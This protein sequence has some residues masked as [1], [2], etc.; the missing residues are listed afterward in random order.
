MKKIK[1]FAVVL[2]AA[3][4]ACLMLVGFSGCTQKGDRE[5]PE[6]VCSWEEISFTPAKCETDASAT[7]KCNGCGKIDTVALPGTATGHTLKTVEKVEATCLKEGREKS[8]KCENCSYEIS[9]KVIPKL[10]HD[11]NYDETS[12]TYKGSKPANCQQGSYCGVCKTY[13]GNPVNNHTANIVRVAER[14]PTCEEDGWKTYV[15]CLGNPEEGI[16]CSYST[17]DNAVVP[18]QGHVASGNKVMCGFRDTCSVCFKEFGNV[19]EHDKYSAGSLAA[20]CGVSAAYCGRCEQYYGEV[21]QHQIKTYDAVEATC[22]TSGFKA[23]ER[24]ERAGC[25]YTT[26]EE[27]AKLGHKEVVYKA[28]EPTCEDFGWE[29]G[30]QCSR[31]HIFIEQ[32]KPVPALN[33]DGMREGQV[34]GQDWIVKGSY[35]P[36]CTQLGFCGICR[37]YY[38]EIR[39]LHD[40]VKVPAQEA[41]CIADGWLE[42]DKCTKCDYSTYKDNIVTSG[43]H[44]IEYHEALEPTCTT[45]GNVAGN[46][47]RYC[48]T[49]SLQE[50]PALGHDGQRNGQKYAEDLIE[51]D[52]IFPDCETRG[53]CGVCDSH[54]GEIPSGHVVGEAATCTKA[55]ICAV[56]EETFGDPIGHKVKPNGRC[57]ICDEYIGLP[58][59]NVIKKSKEEN[60]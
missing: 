60:E 50:I 45:A 59:S 21:P 11:R 58:Q 26:Y 54:Y 37:E 18:K 27:V 42:Y 6:H 1:R 51:A 29:E 40:L 48:D 17:Y 39:G 2:L 20:V 25:S 57:G 41:T 30:S 5:K 10:A 49:W 3:L 24:C 31:C 13:D 28:K 38:G 52:S 36:D 14:K 47:C 16:T 35:F 44:F 12:A 7:K 4:A 43:G 9:G 34:A 55:A 33:H 22:T 46:I 56:C 53:Y 19:L 8:E 32:P 15:K 23:Y